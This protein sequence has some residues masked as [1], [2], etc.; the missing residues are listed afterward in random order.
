MNENGRRVAKRGRFRGESG[1]AFAEK[2]ELELRLLHL[3]FSLGFSAFVDEL[4]KAARMLAIESLLQSGGY[5]FSS[6]EPDRHSDP[7][8]GL[9]EK[10]VGTS[11][12]ND[13]KH[14]KPSSRAERHDHSIDQMR[15][16][17]NCSLEARVAL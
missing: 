11:G 10:P 6:G 9:K 16:L 3:A 14:H 17:V 13:R 15:G 8:H 2:I 12:Q 7:G 5:G 4:A 1:T